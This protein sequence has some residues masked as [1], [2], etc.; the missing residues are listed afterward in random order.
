[1][2]CGCPSGSIPSAQN[3]MSLKKKTTRK[4]FF[5]KVSYFLAFECVNANIKYS[6]DTTSQYLFEYGG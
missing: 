4:T 2:P 6:Y 1:M 3:N 5:L